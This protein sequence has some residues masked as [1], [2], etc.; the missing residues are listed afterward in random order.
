M[1]KVQLSEARIKESN[2]NITLLLTLVFQTLRV[3][4]MKITCHTSKCFKRFALTA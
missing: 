2:I 3:T 1:K 4:K